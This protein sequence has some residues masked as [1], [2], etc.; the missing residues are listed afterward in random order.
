ML[1]KSL[2]KEKKQKSPCLIYFLPPEP[3]LHIIQVNDTKLNL[4]NILCTFFSDFSLPLYFFDKAR[5][6]LGMFLTFP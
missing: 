6:I 3:W 5:I 2:R 4:S 1:I